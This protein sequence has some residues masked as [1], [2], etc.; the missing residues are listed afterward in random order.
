MT[1]LIVAFRN[2]AKPSIKGKDAVLNPMKPYGGSRSLTTTIGG[3]EWS[4]SCPGL[5]T[6]GNERRYPLSRRVVGPQSRSGR[7]F[8]M[9][10]PD[11]SF[12]A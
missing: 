1:K 9:Q 10:T 2:F 6:P 12:V 8:G 11:H 7:S 4:A 3:V 5:F